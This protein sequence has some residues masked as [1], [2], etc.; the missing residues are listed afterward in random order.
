MGTSM[1]VTHMVR[2]GITGVH[3]TVAEPYNIAF[4]PADLFSPYIAGYTLAETFHQ[5]LPFR[6]WM[7]LV[8]GDPLCA[9]YARRLDIDVSISQP[10]VWRGRAVAAL[11]RNRRRLMVTVRDV[12]HNVTSREL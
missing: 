9:P 10:K 7:N 4:P 8:I 12:H 6:Y 3:G 2:A 11:S 1:I 5:K